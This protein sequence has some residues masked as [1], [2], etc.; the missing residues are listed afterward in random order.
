MK[1]A[2]ATAR[3]L[4]TKT[5]ALNAEADEALSRGDVPAY[6]V[7]VDRMI[8]LQTA[9]FDANPGLDGFDLRDLQR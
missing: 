4:K 2:A 5:M 1:A 9:W 7:I 8:E 6:H 3:I